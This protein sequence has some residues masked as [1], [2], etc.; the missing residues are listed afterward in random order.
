MAAPVHNLDAA[1]RVL[2]AV[3]RLWRDRRERW[4]PLPPDCQPQS[5]EEAYAMQVLMR[6]RLV[7][8]RGPVIGWKI[9]LASPTMQTLLRADSPIVGA[10]FEATI[11]QSPARV[12]AR[13][14][15]RLGIECH[16]AFR[17]SRTLPPQGAPYGREV[18]QRAIG[19]CAPVIELIEDRGANDV[20]RVGALQL[21]A[22]NVWNGGLI[23]GP[24]IAGWD[25]LNL[26]RL[27]GRLRFQ[28]VWTADGFGR[29]VMGHPLDAL[30]WLANELPRRGAHLR[31]G[32]WVATGA[33]IPTKIIG[34]GQ[35]AQ[36]H[37]DRLAEVSITVL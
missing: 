14:F 33:I 19:V 12:R 27:R 11:Y 20:T 17:M 35:D 3:D 37:L 34:A 2:G 4:A 28:G 31:A 7:E 6:E 9:G 13:D 8:V 23:L 15:V 32:D 1:N 36:F 26:P 30:T 10:I 16:L 5:A 21:I 29:D 18:V 22:E 24:M 25:R